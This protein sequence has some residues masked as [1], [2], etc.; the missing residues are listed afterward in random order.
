M[1]ESKKS[2][3]QEIYKEIKLNLTNIQSKVKDELDAPIHEA[4]KIVNNLNNMMMTDGKTL[5]QN[6]QNLKQLKLINDQIAVDLNKFAEKY[7]V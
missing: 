4:Q 3:S 5:Q 1:T 7:I 6:V 2:F